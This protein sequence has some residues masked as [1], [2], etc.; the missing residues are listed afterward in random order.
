M[1]ISENVV[2]ISPLYKLAPVRIDDP[3]LVFR[4][5]V[6]DWVSEPEFGIG[7]RIQEFRIPIQNW[8]PALA[9]RI[10]MRD[11]DPELGYRIWFQ[12]LEHQWKIIKQ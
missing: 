8:H 10:G 4:I 9:I 6:Q 11:C 12:Q 7:I 3:W 5:E 1:L 2:L